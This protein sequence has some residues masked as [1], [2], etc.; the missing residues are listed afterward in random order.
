MAFGAASAA[1]PATAAAAQ[2]QPPD[3]PGITRKAPPGWFKNGNN[4]KGYDVGVDQTQPWGGMPS[5]YVKSN[6]LSTAEGLGGMM[7]VTAAEVYRGQRV[8]LSGWMKTQEV[9]DEGGHLWLRVDGKGRGNILAFDNMRDRAPKG[10]TDW[11]EYSIVLDVPRDAEAINYGM[12]LAGRGQIWVSAL[13]V[14]TVGAEVLT[15][16]PPSLP[17][18]PNAP[19]NLGFDPNSGPKT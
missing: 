10:T 18:P 8:R 4:T 9:Q 11:Q 3:V 1:A 2:A 12:F 7:Q 5:A 19:I 17:K 13:T 16:N 15:T 14:T 6:D